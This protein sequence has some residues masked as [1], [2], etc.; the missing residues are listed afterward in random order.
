MTFNYPRSGQAN[1]AEYQIS[2]LPWVS[3]GLSVSQTVSTKIDFPH[4]TQEIEIRP[5]A[6]SVFVSFT[7]GG[8]HG[9]NRVIA[10]TSVPFKFKVRCRSIFLL[11]SG[12]GSTVDVAASLTHV[13][14]HNFPLLTGSAVYP[15]GSEN[16]GIW[17]YGYGQAGTIN[18]GSGLG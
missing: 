1:V 9:T 2:G 18:S 3:G 17:H 6:G 13:L 5:T 10:T 7:S 4:V 14:H 11:G 15:S 16:S 8:L 12:G